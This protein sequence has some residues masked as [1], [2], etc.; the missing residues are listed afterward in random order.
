MPDD[1]FPDKVYDRASKEMDDH[2]LRFMTVLRELG[3][4]RDSPNMDVALHDDNEFYV[5]SSVWMPRSKL[6]ELQDRFRFED[7]DYETRIIVTERVS[8]LLQRKG[9]DEVEAVSTTGDVYSDNGQ[10]AAMFEFDPATMTEDGKEYSVSFFLDQSMDTFADNA[11]E[12]MLE[13]G[14]LTRDEMNAWLE[15]AGRNY[16]I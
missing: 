2:E 8:G 14:S 1:R 12:D 9:S 13:D 3:I 15:K 16:R 5:E 4:Y 10:P 7:L 6:T 11:Y